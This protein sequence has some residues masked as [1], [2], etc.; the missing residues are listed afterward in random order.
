M[1]WLPWCTV[2]CPRLTN[3][4]GQYWHRKGLSP[5]WD[6]VCSTR[7]VRVGKALGHWGHWWVGRC[8]PVWRVRLD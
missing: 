2:S 3:A 6:R 5:L 1:E 8:R 7:R 4:R